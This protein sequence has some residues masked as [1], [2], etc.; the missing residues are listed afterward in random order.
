MVLLFSGAVL[1]L[2]GYFANML[3]NGWVLSLI[4]NLS[5][6]GGF[7]LVMTYRATGVSREMWEARKHFD[8]AA[9]ERLGG[10]KRTGY[11]ITA[12]LAVAVIVP[13]G[14]KLAKLADASL[15]HGPIVLACAAAT[16]VS[17]FFGLRLRLSELRLYVGKSG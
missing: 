7:G 1:L 6:L 15:P 12:V 17:L 10:M 11:L 16:A 13:L 14:M 2:F 9:L 8:D 4:G 5:I 3:E